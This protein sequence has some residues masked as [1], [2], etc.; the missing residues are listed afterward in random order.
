MTTQTKFKFKT[1]RA[2]VKRI[3]AA[4][5]I[6][7]EI[8]TKVDTER[9]FGYEDAELP[10]VRNLHAAH[11]SRSQTKEKYQQEVLEFSMESAKNLSDNLPVSTAGESLVG[12]PKGVVSCDSSSLEFEG[13]ECSVR[14]DKINTVSFQY[15]GI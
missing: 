11:H 1:D 8:P 5:V 12:V 4:M 3:D 15:R 7:N 2:D 9:V 6:K 10:P 14:N 13:R